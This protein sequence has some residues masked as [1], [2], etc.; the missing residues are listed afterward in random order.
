MGTDSGENMTVAEARKL[1]NYAFEVDAPPSNQQEISADTPP[2]ES[3]KLS[4]EVPE[5]VNPYNFNQ[6]LERGKNRQI[7]DLYAE[8]T[9]KKPV[10]GE[11]DEKTD[12]LDLFSARLKKH[13]RLN[14]SL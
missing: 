12:E 11:T 9:Q 13:P 8:R 7:N 10:T 2:A 5:E 14:G 4:P 1:L 3:V 6:M